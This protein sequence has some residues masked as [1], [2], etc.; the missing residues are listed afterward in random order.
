MTMIAEKLKAAGVNA[1][2]MSLVAAWQK[3]A[4]VNDGQKRRMIFWGMVRKDLALQQAACIML[5]EL[6]LKECGHVRID[7]QYH[8]AAPQQQLIAGNPHNGTNHQAS[9]TPPRNV[10]AVPSQT[11][12][13]AALKVATTILDSYKLEDGT[14]IG[15]VKMAHIPSIK[16][17]YTRHSALL[18]MI[19]NH[20]IPDDPQATVRESIKH[21]TIVRMIQKAAQVQD[22]AA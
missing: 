20:A 13:L 22:A 19:Y 17:R 18:D 11:S 15:D 4:Q 7:G 3:A 1:E 10:G 5:D 9:E 8:H 2:R 12:R 16:A 21:E 14:P 6:L